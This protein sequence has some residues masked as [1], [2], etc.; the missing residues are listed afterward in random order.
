[1]ER[2]VFY[3]GHCPMCNG[4]VMRLLRWDRHGRF[5]FAP[6]DGASAVRLLTP[7]MPD[8]LR[9]DT[10]ILCV[11]GRIFL[12]SDAAL[13]ILKGLGLPWSL[14]FAGWIIPRPLRDGVYKMIAAR[15]YT[16]GPRYAE[17]PLPPA[18]FRARFLP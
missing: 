14:L 2:I 17:C 16:F 4:W 11:D 5:R 3:D 12:R 1:M 8:F 10:I 9:E 15:R 7:R 18:G 13:H 6:L